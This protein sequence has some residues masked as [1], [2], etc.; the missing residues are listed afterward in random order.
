MLG[1]QILLEQIEQAFVLGRGHP[2]ERAWRRLVGRTAEL[3]DALC[4]L[5]GVLLLF[6]RA[7]DELGLERLRHLSIRQRAEQSV[8][9]YAHELGYER[10]IEQTDERCTIGGFIGSRATVLDVLSRA[11]AHYAN[12]GQKRIDI[13][14]SRVTGDR[15]GHRSHSPDAI[16]GQRRN[17]FAR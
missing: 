4:N 15:R 10:R 9:L 14:I 12:V 17:R 11:L 7:F 2:I 1:N 6:A 3:H 13:L 8:A 16:S 5:I